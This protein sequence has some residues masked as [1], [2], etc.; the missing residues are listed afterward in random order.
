MASN[1]AERLELHFDEERARDIFEVNGF[2]LEVGSRPQWKQ[3]WFRL[4]LPTA[5][6]CRL[7]SE[8][9][10]MQTMSNIPSPAVFIDP[11]SD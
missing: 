8:T 1:L 10:L 2:T 11:P 3:K 5:S 4:V 7:I 9:I 6:R